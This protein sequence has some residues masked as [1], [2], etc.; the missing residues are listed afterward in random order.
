MSLK[1]TRRPH[2]KKLEMRRTGRFGSGPREIVV[3]EHFDDYVQ[4]TPVPVPTNVAR[5]HPLKKLG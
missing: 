1:S 3:V 5:F 2:G 4:T